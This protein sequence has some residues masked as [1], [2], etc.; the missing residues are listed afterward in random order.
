MSVIQRKVADY[1]GDKIARHGAS[2][3]GVD[4]NGVESQ[5]LRF[6]VLSRV[7][8][9]S[10]PFS[11]LDYGCGYGAFLTY[12]RT[13]AEG[14]FEYFGYDISGE[15]LKQ[16]IAHHG[17]SPSCAWIDTIPNESSFDY[18]IASGIFNVK[19][20]VSNEAWEGYCKQT[21]D[22]INQHSKK[23]F[24]F[25]ML[26]TYSD[27]EFMKD[28]LYYGSPEEVFRH[29][30]SNYSKRV[31]LDHSYPLYEFSIMVTK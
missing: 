1:Y 14:P 8:D 15:M 6:D 7:I 18:V 16:A 10:K 19:M 11:I 3:A 24:A 22:S 28:S 12:L 17:P 13:K 25:N 4:W 29:C 31:L 26:T 23:G 5:F 27:K 2:P 30:R 21:W 9:F 20:D